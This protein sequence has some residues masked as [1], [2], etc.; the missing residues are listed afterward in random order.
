MAATTISYEKTITLPPGKPEWVLVPVKNVPKNAYL[1]RVRAVADAPE[2]N[3]FDFILSEKEDIDG[4]T[5][6][7]A[8]Y[9]AVLTQARLDS[10]EQ[11]YFDLKKPS[12]TLKGRGYL[13]AAAK[14]NNVE[15]S[16]TT[17]FFRVDIEVGEVNLID[18]Q[19]LGVHASRKIPPLSQMLQGPTGPPGAQGVVGPQGTEGVQ[20]TQGVQGS[21]GD[22]GT[23]GTHGSDGQVGAQGATGPQGD[24][25]IQGLTGEKIVQKTITNEIYYN[26]SGA[27]MHDLSSQVANGIQALDL[28]PDAVVTSLIVILN[29][30][31]QLPD[32]GQVVGDYEVIADNEISFH[33]G[34][35]AGDVV[36]AIYV[37]V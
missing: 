35:T 19:A 23:D 21:Q 34:L 22:D 13:Y 20:G 36:Q 9:E 12:E 32:H 33:D 1:T 6:V 16:E 4:K 30:V 37:E 15:Q 3:S 7:I 5:S 8:K 29:G 14:V 11:I 24:Q 18:I 31:V 25:G 28:A 27:T 2:G 10:Q 26:V 17:V